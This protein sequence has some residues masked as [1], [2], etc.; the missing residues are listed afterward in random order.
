MN[1]TSAARSNS[2]AGDKHQP[3]RNGTEAVQPV[4]AWDPYAPFHAKP[5][6][7]GQTGRLRP[8]PSMSL[9]RLR[10]CRHR[11]LRG[12][13]SCPARRLLGSSPSCAGFF[14]RRF[15]R[16]RFVRFLSC[17]PFLRSALLRALLRGGAPHRLLSAAFLRRALLRGFTLGGSLHHDRVPSANLSAWVRCRQ[18][19]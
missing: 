7:K 2:P 8:P 11:R 12:A 4:Q 3:P 16:R 9:D 6:M 10:H 5:R 1:E 18:K 14:C 17:R 15:A 19:A 13:G